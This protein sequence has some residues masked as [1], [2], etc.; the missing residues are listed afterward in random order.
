MRLVGKRGF[1]GNTECMCR[2]HGSMNPQQKNVCDGQMSLFP[3]G[4]LGFSDSD[5]HVE[6][7]V[8][9]R[10]C[11]KTHES[12]TDVH[13]ESNNSLSVCPV[14]VWL[15]SKLLSASARTGA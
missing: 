9:A 6:P 7:A 8:S 15:G 2:T 3:A 12:K 13:H 5:G 1:L 11:W 10:P 14:D 4:L